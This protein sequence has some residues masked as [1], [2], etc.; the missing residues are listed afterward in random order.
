MQ[1]LYVRTVR[2]LHEHSIIGSLPDQKGQKGELLNATLESKTRGERPK[3]L[4]YSAPRS[5]TNWSMPAWQLHGNFRN[6]KIEKSAA[7]KVRN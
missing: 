6:R 5:G 1:A 4:Q 7:T 3:T 2:T